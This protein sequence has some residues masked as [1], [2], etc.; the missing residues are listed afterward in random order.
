MKSVL[1]IFTAAFSSTFFIAFLSFASALPNGQESSQQLANLLK[2]V[3]TFSADFQ[4]TLVSSQGNIMQRVSGHLKAK[5]PGLF[6]W[7][8]APPLEQK[9]IS[10]G[11]QVWLYDPDLEQV[12]IQTLSAQ[13]SQTPALLLSGEVKDIERQYDVAEVTSENQNRLFKL[14]PKSP[15]SLFDSLYLSFNREQQLR[16]MQLKDSLGQQTTLEFS[17][18]QINQ[19][20]KDEIFVFDIPEGIDVIRQ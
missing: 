7:Y 11:D 3:D 10:D 15:D 9:L 6:Y 13:F 4:Q 17:N 18:Q 14:R 5:R 12:T 20:V 19:P 8:T 2:K 16:L 1:S